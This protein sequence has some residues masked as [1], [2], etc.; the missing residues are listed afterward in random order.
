MWDSPRLL[1]A[2]ADALFLGAVAVALW[3]GAQVAMRS[4]AMPL[5]TIVL[6]GDVRHMDAESVV[7][8]LEGR[9]GG[10]FFGVEL[11]DVQTRL[12]QLP[13]VRSATVRR[14]WPDRL[15]AAIEEHRPLAHWSGGR[16]VNTYGELFDGEGNAEL[17]R[18]GGPAGTERLV[19]RRYREFR[20]AL[21]PLGADLVEVSLS[22]RF[23]WQVK[24]TNGI[25]L[26]LGRDDGREPLEARIG[27]FV[28]A[29]PRVVAQLNRRLEH[30]DLRYPNGF[31]IRIQE[32]PPNRAETTVARKRT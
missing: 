10:N 5:R 7:A 29:F 14:A 18:L 1:N 26:E 19:A 2:I 9:I 20:A 22:A 13:W 4:A 3:Y 21:A 24:L 8:Q 17:P 6:A 11:Q 30:V 28:A 12:E 25:V 15:V 23:A 31:A 27:R 16:L 32:L